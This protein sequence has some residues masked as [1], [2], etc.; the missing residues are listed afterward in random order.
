MKKVI[1]TIIIVL[2]VIM[3]ISA[4]D[5]SVNG[6]Y[7][8]Y[9]D[10]SAKTVEVTYKG[11]KYNSYNNEY[12]GNIIIPESII[13]NGTTYSIT[14]INKGAFYNCTT[15]ESITIPSS[16]LYINK[17][18][19]ELCVSLKEVH[20]SDLSAWCKIYFAD[21]MS[22]PLYYAKNLYLDGS[23]IKK[24]IIPN[25]ITTINPYAFYYCSNITSVT[26][27]NSVKTISIRAFSGCSGLTEAT[28][29][30]SVTSIENYA[31]N[32]CNNLHTLI[33]EDGTKTL[34]L[35]YNTYSST[36]TS[37][38]GLFNDCNLKTLHLGRNLS[39]STSN[40]CGYSP[41]RYQTSL[42][43]LTIG[44]NVT[45][46]GDYAFYGCSNLSVL[47]ISDNL[48][49]IGKLSFAIC[50]R[51]A[52]ITIPNTLTTIQSQAFYNCERLGKV[53]ISDLSAWCKINFANAQANPLCYAKKIILNGNE[54]TNFVIPNEISQIKKYA[55]TGCSGLTSVTIHNSVT[56]IG[57]YAF[58][59]CS[60]LTEIKS[61]NT[62]PPMCSTSSFNGAYD[63]L[64][65]IPEGTKEAYTTAE[66]WKG[67]VNIQEVA[68]V[69][70]VL[71]DNVVVKIAIENGNIS[72]NGIENPQIEIYNINGKCIYSG[73]DTTIPVSGT[74]V[75]ILKINGKS[76][77]IAI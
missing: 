70:D 49:K 9:L 61:L 68:G 77:K 30:N 16:I 44:S 69:E 36:D 40:R 57:E 2:N 31:F 32:S 27:P 21:H 18:A 12:S 65:F 45:E 25:N 58:A 42:K 28:I 29:A 37:G 43:Q 39:Y 51:L 13:H 59:S 46:I 26:I 22:N 50:S 8:N 23:L 34:S 54:I 19:F 73:N 75:Y 10:E 24:L 7:Y 76:Y 5:F 53:N 55:F 4:H 64:L 17:Y 14:E 62:N 48:E 47:E 33:I 41:F 63:A 20:I 6:I 72:I 52:S 35:G 3:S 71:I 74:G 56:S 11:E 60:E 38:K 15:L 1:L 66:G 67:F